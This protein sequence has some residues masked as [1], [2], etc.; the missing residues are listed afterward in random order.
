MYN[1]CAHVSI[2]SRY[3]RAVCMQESIMIEKIEVSDL[4]KKGLKHR[5]EFTVKDAKTQ[6]RHKCDKPIVFRIAGFIITI[7]K[8]CHLS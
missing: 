5:I 4:L 1:A 3:H 6:L 2:H 8:E 7:Q